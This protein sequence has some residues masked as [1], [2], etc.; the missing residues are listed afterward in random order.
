MS[1]PVHVS[2]A[3]HAQARRE[4]LRRAA[5]THARRAPLTRASRGGVRATLAGGLRHLADH[6]EPRRATRASA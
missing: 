4:Q 5:R 2:A 1:E 3:V 6:L